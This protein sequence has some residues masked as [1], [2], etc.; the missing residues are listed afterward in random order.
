MPREA[1]G[2]DASPDRH[3]SHVGAAPELD[4][5]VQIPG[6]EPRPTEAETLSSP[7][8]VTVGGSVSA[9]PCRRGVEDDAGD[10]PRPGTSTG[11]LEAHRLRCVLSA[12]HE[13]E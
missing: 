8:T 12:G 3:T 2:G 1:G 10:V 7:G 5:C 9:R 6:G 11:V 13:A 4:V